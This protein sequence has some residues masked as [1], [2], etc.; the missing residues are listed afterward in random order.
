[1][2]D[3]AEKNAYQKLGYRIVID[4][5]VVQ[6]SIGIYPHERKK[7]QPL[8]ISLNLNI[9]TEIN[10]DSTMDNPIAMENKNFICYKQLCDDLQAIVALGHIPLLEDL[11][12]MLAECCFAR[13]QVQSIWLSLKKPQAIKTAKG[14]GIE[15]SMQRK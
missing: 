11:G 8:V 13:K 15:L 7:K 10:T 2:S 9:A 14:A 6:A 12:E 4:E 1:M 5:L 3:M